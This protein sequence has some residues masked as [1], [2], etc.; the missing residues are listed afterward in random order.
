M[1]IIKFYNCAAFNGHGRKEGE[2][3]YL[4]A[5]VQSWQLSQFQSKTYVKYLIVIAL[6]TIEEL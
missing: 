5:N 3:P 6:K 1:C 4:T 2:F